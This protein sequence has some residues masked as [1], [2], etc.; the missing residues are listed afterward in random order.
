MTAALVNGDK[1][2]CQVTSSDVCSTP[3]VNYSNVIK[4]L[5]TTGVSNVSNGGSLAI[6]PNPSKGAFTITGSL[7]NGDDK[8]VSIVITDL[9]GQT[10]YKNITVA[11][12]GEINEHV[13]LEPSVASGMYLVKVTAGDEPVVF[14]IIVDK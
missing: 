10:I 11:H 5:V 1:V 2:F 3:N 7:K 4:V 14:R 12:N 8:Q 6:V 13:S 9:V